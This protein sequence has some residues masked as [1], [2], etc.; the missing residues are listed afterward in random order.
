MKLAG[1]DSALV[2]ANILKIVGWA[3]TG[4][5]ASV[6]LYLMTLDEINRFLGFYILIGGVGP[7]LFFVMIASFVQ[8]QISFQRLVL[9]KMGV[10][11]TTPTTNTP[12]ET[13]E[14]EPPLTEMGVLETTPTTNTP[15]ETKEPEPPLTEKI[16]AANKP[17]GTWVLFLSAGGALFATVQ[18][19]STIGDTVIGGGALFILGAIADRVLSTVVEKKS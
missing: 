8:S 14:P 12:N 18:P 7:G 15:N 4:V 1:S 6:G 11:E 2:T 9:Q 10:L 13:K 19:G 16:L 5:C 3:C 17:I